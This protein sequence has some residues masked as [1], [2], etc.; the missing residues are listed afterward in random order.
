[1]RRK[2]PL[3]SFSKI[4]FL[5]A[6]LFCPISQQ[7]QQNI[8]PPSHHSSRRTDRKHNRLNYHNDDPNKT[9]T[10]R[11]T[12]HD[13]MGGGSR[14]IVQNGGKLRCCCPTVFGG[15]VHT[16]RSRSARH[17]HAL[18]SLSLSFTRVALL[19]DNA[20][21][22]QWRREAIRTPHTQRREVKPSIVHM[23]HKVQLSHG[24]MGLQSGHKVQSQPTG[25]MTGLPWKSF[26]A[27]NLQNKGHPFGHL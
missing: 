10:K 24:R 6:L 13:E 23:G 12:P 25:V 5:T 11:N 16:Q 21:H 2:P 22:R 14:D 17:T 9:S 7:R 4:Y 15:G 20:H 27:R 3:V 1:M 8:P 18:S 19:Q 26:S